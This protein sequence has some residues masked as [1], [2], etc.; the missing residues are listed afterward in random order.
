MT[1]LSPVAYSVS[2]QQTAALQIPVFLYSCPKAE[3]LVD[4]MGVLTGSHYYAQPLT[5]VTEKKPLLLTY[6]WTIAPEWPAAFF[7]SAALAFSHL[8]GFNDFANEWTGRSA[9]AHQRE[10]FSGII[11]VE[12]N[13]HRCILAN[14]IC[15]TLTIGHQHLANIYP[16]EITVQRFLLREA[17]RK[18][19]NRTEKQTK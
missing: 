18:D 19:V 4:F 5:Q 6:I 3:A 17:K 8:S 11:R 10:V 14:Q 13:L 12:M 16:A 9:P 15:Y 7:C 1:A 2:P